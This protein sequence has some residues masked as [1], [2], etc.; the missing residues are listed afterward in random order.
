MMEDAQA[1]GTAL[2]ALAALG[3]RIAV[4]DFGTGYSSLLYLRRYP[5]SVLKVDRA[6]VAA[7]PATPATTPSAPA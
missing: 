3:V 1:A 5:I 4:D 7:S 2:D 6:F